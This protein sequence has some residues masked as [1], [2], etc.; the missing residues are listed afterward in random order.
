MRA[1][2][3]SKDRKPAWRMRLRLN[4]ET[5]SSRYGLEVLGTQAVVDAEAPGLEQKEKMRWAQGR[6]RW[7]AMRPMTRGSW[8]TP[9]AAALPCSGD[10]QLAV[11]AAARTAEAVR[12]AQLIEYW[13][14]AR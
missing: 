6:T 9:R 5:N 1:P 12:P 10:Q 3:A 14:Q 4:R 8:W 2:I 7:A 13:A 11:M